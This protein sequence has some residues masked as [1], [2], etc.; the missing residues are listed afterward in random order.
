MWVDGPAPAA[1][2]S[3]DQAATTAYIRAENLFVLAQ[4]TRIGASVAAINGE[5]ARIS[6]DCP[7]VIA[8]APRDE[9][10]QRL[11]EEV[12]AAVLF[13]GVVPDR[14][15]TLA[16]AQR[17]SRLHWNNSRIANLVRLLASDERA[18]AN[19]VIPDVCANLRS[20]VASRYR[21]LSLDTVGFLKQVNAIGKGV[22]AKEESLE[23]VVS[24]LL[25]RNESPSE[26]RTA[27]HI[28]RLEAAMGKR[29]LHAFAAAMEVVERAL[30]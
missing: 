21:T 18:I 19:L 26:R 2:T 8:D 5:A 4:V 16:F 9:Q 25:A 13:S 15:A 7:S 29:A 1:T 11:R 17:I 28:E 20:W 12:S 23:E 14:S 30:G 10:L 22:G 3:N 6:R 24:R 27:K